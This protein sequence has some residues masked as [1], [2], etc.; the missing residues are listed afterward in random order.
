MP[1]FSSGSMRA[2]AVASVKRQPGPLAAV[3]TWREQGH[4]V[5]VGNW[6]V[7]LGAKGIS[8][9]Q[10]AY[11]DSVFER[12]TQTEEWKSELEK[13]AR[14]GIYAPSAETRAWMDKQYAEFSVVLGELGLVK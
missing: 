1:H 7:V 4:D 2:I 6:R 10:L 8:A 13:N 3:P 12:L 5:V 11:W 9:S 14:S